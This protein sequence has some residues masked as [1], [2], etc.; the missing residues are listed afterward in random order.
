RLPS[1]QIDSSGEPLVEKIRLD[2]I[3]LDA[4]NIFAVGERSL[5]EPAGAEQ[6][7]FR[8][9]HLP[10]P[11]VRGR[12]AAHDREVAG[13]LLLDVD[14][15]D[16]PVRRRARFVGDLHGLEEVEVLD[17]SLG[18]IDQ[19]AVVRIAFG[20]IELAPDHIIT[21]PGVATDIDTFDI[22]AHAFV[23]S[24]HYAD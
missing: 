5:G 20:Y 24:E 17:P 12:E 19:G 11:A 4:A 2:E 16:H 6:V 10:H 8:D 13:R 9:R 23:Q 1:K 18:A 14:V 22:G 15:D 7:L 3:K 21:G